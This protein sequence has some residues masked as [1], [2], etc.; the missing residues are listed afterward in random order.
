MRP[1][2]LGTDMWTPSGMTARLLTALATL[3]TVTACKDLTKVSAPDLTSPG[4]LNNATGALAREAGAISAFSTS[5]STTVLASGLISD[6]LTDVEGLSASQNAEDSRHLADPPTSVDRYPYAALSVARVN[7]LAAIAALEHYNPS[8]PSQIGELFALLGTVEV[9]MAEQ[10]CA[11][12]RLSSVVNGT[13]VL[14]T[15]LT[16][17][18]LLQDALADFDSAAAYGKDSVRIAA[19][20]SVGQGRVLLDLARFSDAATAVATVPTAYVYQANYSTAVNQSSELAF[21]FSFQAAAVADREGQNGLD[22]VSANDPRV[23]ITSNGVSTDGVTPDYVPTSYVNNLAVP[24]TVASGVEARLIGAE[25]ALANHDAT[26]WLA[27][28][29]A[30]R[31]DAG[32]TGV[33]GLTPLADP[34]TDTGRVSLMFRE[35]AFWLFLTG[36]R[37]GDLRR[38]IRQYG[39]D[40]SVVFPNG[41]YKPTAQGSYG[42]DVNFPVAGDLANTN[43]PECLD[44]N[45]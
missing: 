29:N 39:L 17:A 2:T 31:A 1:L 45:P 32:E 38:L 34:V 5:Y 14:G 12:V 7:A 13:P 40:Q 20:A 16:S 27:D 22:F 10:M 6:E 4:S 28:L 30:L 44:R 23:L 37:Q 36:H 19:L 8:P 24:I 35:R 43:A 25:A 3:I 9:S 41:P 11:G 21:F 15:P 18:A 33:S 42:T 26:T